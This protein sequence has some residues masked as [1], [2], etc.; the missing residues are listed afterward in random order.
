M[1][2]RVER[3][4]LIGGSWITSD[5]LLGRETRR[6]VIVASWCPACHHLLRKLA[7]QPRRSRELIL[8]LDD[9]A[10]RRNGT[11][12]ILTDAASLERYPLEFY[13]VRASGSGLARQVTHYPFRLLC[14]R[15]ECTRD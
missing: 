2:F 11:G 10:E 8:F 7:A 4:R 9:E 6:V 5:D 1:P 3:G 13:V 12:A 14:N 15:R